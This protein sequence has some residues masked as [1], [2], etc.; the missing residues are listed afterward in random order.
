MLSLGAKISRFDL[1]I[2]MQGSGS[3]AL[4]DAFTVFV[5]DSIQTIIQ[6]SITLYRI[7]LVNKYTRES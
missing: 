1:T 2:N 4:F 5:M 7:L 3:E 6:G